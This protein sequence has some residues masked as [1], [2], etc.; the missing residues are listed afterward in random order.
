[1]SIFISY[2]RG[3][4][5]D[6]VGRIK[7][8]LQLS[9]D[10][11]FQDVGSIG[12][13][14]DFIKRTTQAVKRADVV[15]VVIGPDWTRGDSIH[16]PKD[17]VRIEVEHALQ[18]DDVFVVPVL[19]NDAN[20]PAESEVPASL[21]PLLRRNAVTVDSGA[22]FNHHI[23]QLEAAIEK[24][25]PRRQDSL[26]AVVPDTRKAKGKSVPSYVPIAA[27]TAI[28]VAAAFVIGGQLWPKPDPEPVPGSSTT[29]G[30]SDPGATE[31][32]SDGDQ[33]ASTTGGADIDDTKEEDTTDKNPSPTPPPRQT[34]ASKK[35]GKY[36]HCVL[37]AG[38]PKCTCDAGYEGDPNR[39]CR[40][41]CEPSPE[42]CNGKDDDCD[43]QVDEGTN[44]SG[45]KSY[46]FDRDGD[47]YFVDIKCLCGPADGRILATGSKGA[48]PNDCV[49]Q[50]P[51]F[52]SSKMP[53]CDNKAS[54]ASWDWN[55][56][57]STELESSVVGRSENRG[58]GKGCNLTVG[59]EGRP[60]D[61]GTRG[62]WI[63][64]C[65]EI[66]GNLK[67]ATE[68]KQQRCR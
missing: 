32:T 2:R 66:A 16:A 49:K 11:V 22:D 63:V 54:S 6:I 55:H 31:S 27:G 1:M 33:S 9:F 61:C 43:G 37:H 38:A 60:A 14:D 53:V 29:S 34:C 10:D 13:G 23:R 67:T 8:R 4:T 50:N 26:G 52:H 46:G 51:A 17:Y 44:L 19:V 18:R 35:C 58:F 45:C 65:K 56:D 21:H 40:K 28:I 30:E 64:N 7:D 42:V 57:G 68:I 48:D 12:I 62:T 20:M 5:Q 3:S 59:W 15:L 47:R 24:H 25:V 39:E 41:G 36:A